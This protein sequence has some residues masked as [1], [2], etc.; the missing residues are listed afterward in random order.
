MAETIRIAQ[1]HF[2]IS[3]VAPLPVSLKQ[4][5]REF[6]AS[7]RKRL[8]QDDDRRTARR[9]PTQ[10]DATVLPLDES[11]TPRAKPLPG[12]VVDLSR[13]GLGMVTAAAIEVKHVVVQIRHPARHVQVLGEV[14][15]TKDIGRGIHGAGIQFLLRFGR[16][17]ITSDPPA[18]P[19]T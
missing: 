8:R 4:L 3:R 6:V 5:V 1:V 18:A 9:V 14:V 13:H 11:W 12:M 17:S 2:D 10:L 15:W 16:S 7:R 19:I